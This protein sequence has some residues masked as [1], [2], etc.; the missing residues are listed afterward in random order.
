ML[1]YPREALR[2]RLTSNGNHMGQSV[3]DKQS[4][5]SWVLWASCGWA[6]LN[7]F[8]RR[9]IET[10]FSC[11]V[12]GSGEIGLEYKNPHNQSGCVPDELKFFLHCQRHPRQTKEVKEIKRAFI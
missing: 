5:V 7:N 12:H 6:N 3:Y 11:R 4:G 2:D 10:A 8:W 9:K 1:P